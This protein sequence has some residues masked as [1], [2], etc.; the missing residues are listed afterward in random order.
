MNKQEEM[1]RIEIKRAEF[2]IKQEN[3]RMY[4][5]TGIVCVFFGIFIYIIARYIGFKEGEIKP[6]VLYSF[7]T[8]ILVTKVIEFY[9]QLPK[10]EREEIT[11]LTEFQTKK[12]VIRIWTRVVILSVFF[13]IFGYIILFYVGI[14]EGTE[15]YNKDLHAFRINPNTVYSFLT[16]VLV[17]KM[18]DY[19]LQPLV[20]RGDSVANDEGK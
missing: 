16:G 17:T 20:G 6:M 8:G 19:F 11:E 13:V 5:R 18:I 2:D 1:D 9:M 12:E 4:V 10:E 3:V 14:P 15:T 7:L